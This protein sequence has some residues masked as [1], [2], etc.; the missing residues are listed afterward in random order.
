M[1]T[2]YFFREQG[3]EWALKGTTRNLEKSF[4]LFDL[5]NAGQCYIVGSITSADIEPIERSINEWLTDLDNPK[6]GFFELTDAEVVTL[7]NQYSQ[8]EPDHM[9]ALREIVS[10]NE[11][12]RLSNIQVQELLEAKGV[13]INHVQLGRSLAAL[14]LKKRQARINGKVRLCYHL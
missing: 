7:C 1:K 12:A 8:Q 11:G 3:S 13:H 10:E 9:Q 14:G 4:Q 5:N 6:P 2:I